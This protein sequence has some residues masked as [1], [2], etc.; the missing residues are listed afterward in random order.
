[1]SAARTR[2]AASMFKARIRQLWDLFFGFDYFIAHR[3]FDAHEYA[4]NLCDELEKRGFDCFLDERNYETGGNLHLMQRLALGRTTRLIVIVSPLAHVGRP[5]EIDWLLEE[6]R[7][8]KR[9]R[10][11]LGRQPVIA[12]VG[13]AWSLSPDENPDSRLLAELP[14]P[15]GYSLY[16]EDTESACNGHP[17][18]STIDKL[19]TDFT[20]LRRRRLRVRA[21][22]GIAVLMTVLAGVAV[23]KAVEA[24][25]QSAR[26]QALLVEASQREQING[27]ALMG[28][29]QRA[30]VNLGQAL[31][32]N[33]AN[34]AAARLLQS[35]VAAMQLNP[36]P[37][38]ALE[39]GGPVRAARA[40]PDGNHVVA[41]FEDGTVVGL[42]ARNGGFAEAFR[43]VK[44]YPPQPTEW[45]PDSAVFA[46]G[47]NAGVEIRDGSTGLVVATIPA[48]SRPG[49][50]AGLSAFA[51]RPDGQA[52]VIGWEDGMLETW[53]KQPHG[54]L[55][56]A[57]VASDLARPRVAWTSE[58]KVLEGGVS[59]SGGMLRV[60]DSATLQPQS[61]NVSLPAR[62]EWLHRDACG[63]T[64]F[65][66]DEGGV[67]YLWH[68][69]GDD[70]GVKRLGFSTSP[71]VSI[72]VQ[73]S[74]DGRFWA[75][76]AYNR[77]FLIDTADGQ[78]KVPEGV[79]VLGGIASL[80]FA[81]DG[82]RLFVATQSGQG[83]SFD[84][85]DGGP[86]R[87]CLTLESPMLATFWSEDLARIVTVSRHG[88]VGFW[89]GGMQS[90]VP[91][92][93]SGAGKETDEVLAVRFDHSGSLWSLR[94]SG[95]MERWRPGAWRREELARGENTFAS[96][97]F[98]D[99]KHIGVV[100]AGQ[101]LQVRESASMRVVSGAFPLAADVADFDAS[102]ALDRVV[103]FT[104]DR[105]V[106]TYR[107]DGTFLWGIPEALSGIQGQVTLIPEKRWVLITGNNLLNKPGSTRV[108]DLDSGKPVGR[109]LIGEGQHESHA[110]LADSSEILTVE[111]GPLQNDW[112]RLWNPA[113]SL[114]TVQ[115]PIPASRGNTRCW[116]DRG[117]LQVADSA[118]LLEFFSIRERSLFAFT[119][120]TMLEANDLSEDG[121][122]LAAGRKDGSLEIREVNL[123]PSAL[124]SEETLDAAVAAFSGSRL[125][126]SGVAQIVPLSERAELLQRAH[127][128]LA[129]ESAA[130][131]RDLLLWKFEPGPGGSL[132]P[133]FERT[134]RQE[135]DRL[136]GLG[137][138]ESARDAWSLDPTHPLVHLAM[139]A[140]A[141][142]QLTVFYRGFAL[143][144]LPNDRMLRLRAAE[145]LLAQG[146]PA[147]ARKQLEKATASTIAGS[148]EFR[149]AVRSLE[150]KLGQQKP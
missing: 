19:A 94:K 18:T 83:I 128:K 101:A 147:E 37:L 50:L 70:T 76:S 2:M 63:A 5:G 144:H 32:Y 91:L 14:L 7:E 123:A 108:L 33:R 100:T 9:G 11:L 102:V 59:S 73:L 58:R 72:N 44:T 23:W 136:I 62:P 82:L 67:A 126:A 42:A 106:N 47:T 79:S 40:S 69:A 92:S 129:A 46:Q 133:S 24:W 29:P 30:A 119:R 13:T 10:A 49:M 122:F 84:I 88:G 142:P 150:Q 85:A 121:R 60:L 16:I 68:L 20:E 87:I 22:T 64:A 139:A 52:I 138:A 75:F 43:L 12:P 35:A 65:V 132:S 113:T 114:A 81:P 51:F 4:K 141:D 3:W 99:G 98:L 110:W 41:C 89:E 36:A 45:A 54:W 135:A 125:D 93:L 130:P 149:K 39:L 6:V 105:A 143:R 21:L 118:G 104:R 48:P 25:Q 115:F 80:H 96:A 26:R 74:P 38:A 78:P 148:V 27:V 90:S 124:P 140:H 131:L 71:R 145:M 117:I 28:S 53:E 111:K 127:R 34:D 112:V 55:Q 103:V 95:V 66:V 15:A 86:D 77:F 17:H 134:R 116:P 97:R 61:A 109:E 56:R 1:M 31:R 57:K 137:S 120:G 107:L 146:Q 8:F